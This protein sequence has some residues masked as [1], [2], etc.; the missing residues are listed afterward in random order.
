MKLTLDARRRW[1][2]F[3]CFGA[4]IALSLLAAYLLEFLPSFEQK[5]AAQCQPLGLVGRMVR[6]FPASMTGSR[7]GPKECKCFSPGSS[8]AQ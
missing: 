7:E 3:S 6:V 2:V 4:F 1:F 5:C 8:G